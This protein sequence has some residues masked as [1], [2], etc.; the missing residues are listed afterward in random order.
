MEIKRYTVTNKVTAE[1]R[2]VIINITPD[3]NGEWTAS[4]YTCVEKYANRCKK[5][6][7]IQKSETRHT[8]G[9][10]VSAE[11]TAPARAVTIREAF[12][13]KRVM[14]DEQRISAAERL[15]KAR[16]LKAKS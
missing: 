4:L 6:G 12:P 10:F 15:K 8:D 14:T 13:E 2:E 3:E 7:W 9:S 16:E 1:E 11:Y 5:K